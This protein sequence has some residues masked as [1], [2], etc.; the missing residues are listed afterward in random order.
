[1]S[2]PQTPLTLIGRLN[3]REIP[4]L[5]ESSWEEF[6]DLYH[7]AV[8]ICVAGSFHRYG[9]HGVDESFVEDVT[10]RVFQSILRD[11]DASGFD[12]A[13]GRF[14]HFLSSICLR[15]VVDFIRQHKND[16]RLETLHDD[17]IYDTIV[18]DPFSR[19]IDE[20]F[21]DALL[22]TL[23]SALRAQVS[24]RIFMIFELVKLNGEDPAM[25]AE[26][27]GVRRGVVDNSVFKATEK[28]RQIAQN[29]EIRRELDL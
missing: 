16:A 19:K 12:P 18:D 8:R 11:A 13:R 1:M 9:W 22:G 10:L 26:Q 7:H 17:E 21:T 3:Q 15:R 27:L 29:S 4:R 5:W 6:F 28:L 24:P 25:V 23:L 20:A 2:F 14:R